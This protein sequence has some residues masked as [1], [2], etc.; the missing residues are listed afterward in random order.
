[1]STLT[2]TSHWPHRIA[3]L[4]SDAL[5]MPVLWTLGNP[6]WRNARAGVFGLITR[7]VVAL[8]FTFRFVQ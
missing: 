7:L 1:M 4:A 3:Y 6:P 5:R 8:A 2:F